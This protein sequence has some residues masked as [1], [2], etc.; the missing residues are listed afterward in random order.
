M[1]CKSWIKPACYI[2]QRKNTFAFMINTGL[3]T[4]R[5]EK[6]NIVG[7]EIP[8]ASP[9]SLFTYFKCLRALQKYR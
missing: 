5:I 1:K 3:A 4:F 7:E 9:T 2:L 8:E 6:R